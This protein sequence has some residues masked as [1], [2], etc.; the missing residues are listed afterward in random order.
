MVEI[1]HILDQDDS[2]KGF[3]NAPPPAAFQVSQMVPSVDDS[4]SPLVMYVQNGPNKGRPI[5]SYCNRVGHI[6]DRCYKK[7]GFPPG[8]TPKGKF[9]DKTQ[10][11]VPVAAQ[12]T[13]APSPAQTPAPLSGL[14][15]SLSQDQ[16][17]NIIAHFTS[18]LS[19]TVNTPAVAGTSQSALDHT[20]I[21]FSNS[22]YSF[23]GILAVSQHTLSNDTWVIDSGATHH[24]SYDRKLF[25]SID[26]S[27]VN[28]VNL[29]NGSRVKISGVGL[30]RL[31]K[32]IL[33]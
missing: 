2:Q 13:L 8:F 24:V 18:Q 10:K 29:P 4:T 14:S 5:C 22:T 23:V 1:Y 30:V 27:I 3:S 28:C 25:V 32:D 9:G 7:H 20:G 21:S 12:V 26:T 31:N 16:L 19:T 17:Q 6:V 33:L 11:P 15:G